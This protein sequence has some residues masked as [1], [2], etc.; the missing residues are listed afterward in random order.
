M[1][2]EY[3]RRGLEDADKILVMSLLIIIVVFILTAA[4]LFL[5]KIV[6]FAIVNLVISIDLFFSLWIYFGVKYRFWSNREKKFFNDDYVRPI[7]QMI[8][9]SIFTTIGII[10]LLIRPFTEPRDLIQAFQKIILPNLYNYVYTLGGGICLILGVFGM[11]L[12]SI[13]HYLGYS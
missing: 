4:I 1:D 5:L 12:G 11:I 7:P 8:I 2:E 9:G 6:F 3:Y 13:L 10:L